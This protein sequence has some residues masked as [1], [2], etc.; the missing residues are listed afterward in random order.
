MVH[1]ERKRQIREG[2][3]MNRE[4][5]VFGSNLAGIHGAGSAKAAVEKYGAVYGHGVGLHGDSYAI[6]TKDHRIQ[7]LP[8]Q[9]VGNYVNQFIDFARQHPEMRFFVVAIGCGL[10]G[11]VPDQIGPM[12]ADA[13]D[14]C[15]L[16]DEFTP[17]QRKAA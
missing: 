1:A 14:N 6:P 13:P 7:T 2:E 11:F 5:F 10:A 3:A 17:Y 9:M 12:F 16:P 15:L 8:L 4:I